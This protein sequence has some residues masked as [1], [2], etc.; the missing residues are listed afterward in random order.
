MN[1]GFTMK[2]WLDKDMLFQN[3]LGLSYLQHTFFGN[4][5]HVRKLG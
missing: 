1:I 2:R 5:L 4:E 3:V